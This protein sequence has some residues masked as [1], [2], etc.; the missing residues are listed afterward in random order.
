LFV[1]KAEGLELNDGT[2]LSMSGGVWMDESTEMVDVAIMSLERGTVVTLFLPIDGLI[3]IETVIESPL[4]RCRGERF[5][6]VNS[7]LY[8]D[9]D[10]TFTFV[11]YL[12]SIEARWHDSGD[13]KSLETGGKENWVCFCATFEVREGVAVGIVRVYSRVYIVF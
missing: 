8:P 13:D 7:L 5:K 3:G 6:F 2:Q 4:A 12:V 1:E 10:V 9:F 11:E